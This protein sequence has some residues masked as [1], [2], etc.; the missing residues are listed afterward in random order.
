MPTWTTA[1]VTGASSGI[2]DA[3]ARRLA[4]AG[5]QL[6]VVARSAD[7]LES[8]AAELRSRHGVRVEV[9]PADL[10]DAGQRAAVEARAAADTDPVDLL[11]NNAGFGS[12]GRFWKSPLER[13][14]GQVD[15]NVTA[16]VRLSHAALGQMVRRGRGAV[17]NVASVA[18]LQPLPGM[19]IYAATKAFVTTFTEGLHE[20]LRGTGVTATAVLPGFTRT[21]FQAVASETGDDG[22]GIPGFLYQEA[23]AVAAE[24]LE[25]AAAGR[26]VCVT[27]THN[28]LAFAAIAAVPRSV[29]RRVAGMVAR[30]M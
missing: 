9:L 13:Q 20:E 24:A 7:A 23:E 12:Q 2:G 11:V 21:K 18:G 16:L 4:A 28:R 10:T 1:L 27:G 5:T 26:A 14:T 29:K 15:L 6:V 19:S 22:R 3:L 30:R 17:V 25:A 8:L